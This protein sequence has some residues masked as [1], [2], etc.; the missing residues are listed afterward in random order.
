ME[1]LKGW[2]SRVWLSQDPDPREMS[3][4]DKSFVNMSFLVCFI[5]FVQSISQAKG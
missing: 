1:R 3:E 4:G 2:L 5:A